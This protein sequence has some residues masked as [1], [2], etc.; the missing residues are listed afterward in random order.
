MITFWRR[1][2]NGCQMIITPSGLSHCCGVHTAT[3]GAPTSTKSHYRI[4]LFFHSLQT[5]TQ[6]FDVKN[7]S[8]KMLGQSIKK[9]KSFPVEQ[10]ERAFIAYRS[11]EI[12][13]LFLAVCPTGKKK[14]PYWK[15]RH[16]YGQFINQRHKTSVFTTLARLRRD[17]ECGSS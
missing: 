2:S 15:V 4:Q 3:N 5:H 16:F 12:N 17:G 1:G 11:L 10:L 13:T 14:L 7:E 6:S 9:K 8:D